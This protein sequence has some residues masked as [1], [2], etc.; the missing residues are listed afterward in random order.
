MKS[1][2]NCNFNEII[3]KIVLKILNEQYTVDLTEF[4]D[5][6]REK[7]IKSLKNCLESHGYIGDIRTPDGRDIIY[8]HKELI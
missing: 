7:P 1:C 8:I 6:L 2:E 5:I 4:K 3:Q